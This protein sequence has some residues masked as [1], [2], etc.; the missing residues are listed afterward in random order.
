[1]VKVYCKDRYEPNDSSKLSLFDAYH[2]RADAEADI[3]ALVD[4]GAFAPG[5]LVIRN[6]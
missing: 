1:M 2:S 4:R 3:R 6:R 5:E